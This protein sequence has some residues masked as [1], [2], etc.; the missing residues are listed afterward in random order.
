M[1]N[2]E[3]M[4][5]YDSEITKGGSADSVI[6]RTVKIAFEAGRQAEREEIVK[7]LLPPITTPQTKAHYIANEIAEA[8]CIA[9]RARGDSK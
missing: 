2:N 7:D 3:I 6:I 1:T 4:D 9:I 5:L 8:L